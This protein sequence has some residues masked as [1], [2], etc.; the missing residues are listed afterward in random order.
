MS[1]V[2]MFGS[3]HVLQSNL[4]LLVGSHEVTR[5]IYLLPTEQRIVRINNM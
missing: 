3:C 2:A 4:D 1:L 5:N